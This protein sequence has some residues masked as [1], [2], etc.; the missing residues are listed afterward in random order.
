MILTIRQMEILVAAADAMNFS[1]AAERLGI[2]Q[3]SLSETI[4]RMEAEL[5]LRFLREQLGR[6][7]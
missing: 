7:R 6:C 4:R 1:E 2:T 3:P 5:G